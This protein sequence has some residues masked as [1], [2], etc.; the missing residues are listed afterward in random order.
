MGLLG[1]CV[2]C[3]TVKNVTNSISEHHPHLSNLQV[4]RLLL[5]KA[6]LPRLHQPE[7]CFPIPRFPFSNPVLTADLVPRPWS[8]SLLD[9]LRRLTPMNHLLLLDSL[10]SRGHCYPPPSY[11]LP[12]IRKPR[13]TG[14]QTCCY[15]M[16]HNCQLPYLLS[17][18]L[19]DPDY[20]LSI[21]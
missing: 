19:T 15:R 6:Y 16:L 18:A 1:T 11:V 8:I 7:V 4:S 13:Q 17:T 5:F 2:G 21:C 14:Y 20:P 9:R 10:F 12:L 3:Q